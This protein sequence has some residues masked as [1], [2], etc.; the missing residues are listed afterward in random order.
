MIDIA[1]DIAIIKFEKPTTEGF[2][3]YRDVSDVDSSGTI[4]YLEFREDNR[5]LYSFAIG[6]IGGTPVS[7][8]NG[9]W[10]DKLIL[11]D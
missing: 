8:M 1:I 11:K 5:E 9:Y 7:E 6:F 10:S 4:V 2:Y 3:G